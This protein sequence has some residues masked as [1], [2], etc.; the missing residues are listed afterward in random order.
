[1]FNLFSFLLAADEQKLS[2]SPEVLYTSGSLKWQL[3]IRKK[4]WWW[5]FFSLW[6]TTNSLLL[7]CIY[8]VL[9]K[10]SKQRIFSTLSTVKAEK[11]VLHVLKMQLCT[12][13]PGQCSTFPQSLSLSLL[14]QQHKGSPILQ[15]VWA[16]I[17]RK[18]T[19]FKRGKTKRLSKPYAN[20]PGKQ[21]NCRLCQ[22]QPPVSP[23]R[24]AGKLQASQK[25][26][27]KAAGCVNK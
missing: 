22:P 26:G 17:R 5:G 12:R 10:Q 7:T 6:I 23:W 11:H 21:H 15:P 8:Y 14:A 9:S 1:M 2:I 27:A 24:P 25:R 19:I 13:P 20:C 4:I 16:E 18:G 3:I